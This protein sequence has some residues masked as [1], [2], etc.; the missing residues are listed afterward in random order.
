MHFP[1]SNQI[2]IQGE[3]GQFDIT[4]SGATVWFQDTNNSTYLKI[5]ATLTSQEIQFN[6]DTK[7]LRIENS[8][9]TLDGIVVE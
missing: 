4:R 8:Q 9:I 7:I 3:S 2:I 1:G 6:D 5:P